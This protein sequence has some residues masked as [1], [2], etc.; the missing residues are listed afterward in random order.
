L[1]TFRE[2]KKKKKE[3]KGSILPENEREGED[4]RAHKKAACDQE[5]RR[6][7][8]KKKKKFLSPQNYSQ[9]PKGE[10]GRPG[11]RERSDIPPGGGKGQAL[12]KGGRK[13]LIAFDKKK[14]GGGEEK[15]RVRRRRSKGRGHSTEVSRGRKK[16][17]EEIILFAHDAKREEGGRTVF[18][19]K[20]R[21][22]K[23][24]RGKKKISG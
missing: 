19:D 15:T 13:S 2:K 21:Q 1:G 20:V 8:K 12:S 11:E 10:G 4:C 22:V 6:G 24:G 16:K 9:G 18:I 7:G 23:G 3:K 14:R 17:G 5:F